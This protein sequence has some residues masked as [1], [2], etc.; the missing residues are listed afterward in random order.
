[1]ASPGTTHVAQ[2]T[3]VSSW[4]EFLNENIE[5]RDELFSESPFYEI[6]RDLLVAAE[7]D[8]TA[9]SRAVSKFYDLYKADVGKFNKSEGHGA[10]EYLNSIAVIGFE[11]APKLW[12]TNWRHERIA[13]FLIA[14]KSG[15]AE[16]FDEENPQFIWIGWGLAAAASESWN[17]GHDAG[18]Q[19]QV[20]AAVNHILFSGEAFAEGAKKPLSKWKFQ[21]NAT[22]WKLWASKIREVVETVDETAR[23]DLKEKAQKALGRAEV[24]TS[25][26]PLQQLSSHYQTEVQMEALKGQTAFIT[27]ASMGIGEAIALALAEHGVNVALV[28]RSKDK[29]EAV[30]DKITPKFSEIKVGVYPV[31]IQ[32]QPDIEKVVK[33]AVSELGQIDILINNAGLALG[34]PGRFWE[35]PIDQVTQ[36][37]NTNINGVMFT[38]HAVLNY[39]MWE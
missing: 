5:E 3:E 17:A 33:K 34:A 8:E 37:S 14:I 28:S 2:S 27:G 22:K 16:K 25:L 12:Y 31:D 9:V 38:T 11:V 13:E 23:W 19:A 39:S 1:M 24:R 10:G 35:I 36:V 7:D 20:L 4:L 30:R 26:D 29:L 21:L 32:N 18:R 6:V 15:G